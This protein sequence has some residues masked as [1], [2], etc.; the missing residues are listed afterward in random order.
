VVYE[1]SKSSDKVYRISVA[2]DD[3]QPGIFIYI[4][5]IIKEHD[6]K[7]L[8]NLQTGSTLAFFGKIVGVSLRHLKVDPAIIMDSENIDFMKKLVQKKQQP[9]TTATQTTNKEVKISKVKFTCMSYSNKREEYFIKDKKGR[10]FS[11]PGPTFFSGNVNFNADDFY[12]ALVDACSQNRDMSLMILE[13]TNGGYGPYFYKFESD[14]RVYGSEALKTR[15]INSS[16]SG[17]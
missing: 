15:L 5:I 2:Q 6:E 10:L 13:G 3:N 9:A 14:G 7:I 12:K 11:V 1:I 8:Y 16:S 4:N 17:K